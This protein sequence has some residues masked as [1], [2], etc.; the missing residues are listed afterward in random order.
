MVLGYPFVWW[1]K[2]WNCLQPSE[3]VLCCQIVNAQR[4]FENP[5]FNKQQPKAWLKRRWGLVD[6]WWMVISNRF[7]CSRRWR[8]KRI[9]FGGRRGG[10][11]VSG[12]AIKKTFY[13][14]DTRWLVGH[15]SARLEF[16]VEADWVSVVPGAFF[17]TCLPC[18]VFF[19]PY[20]SQ[21]L[22]LHDP[23]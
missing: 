4:W 17:F 12:V 6:A 8:I 16:L 21:S 13:I 23:V 11:S 19:T 3:I 20:L 10:S 22:T 9:C 5:Q 18:S 7:I 15:A 2:R 1:K 14:P